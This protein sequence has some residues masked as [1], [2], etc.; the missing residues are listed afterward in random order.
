MALE[1]F[2][3]RHALRRGKR[4]DGLVAER[5]LLGAG[6]ARRLGH[7]RRAV[8]HQRLI[9]LVRPIPFQHGEFRVMQ[10]AALAV[11]EH[12]G[13]FEN[14]CLAGRQQLLAGKFRRG[15]QVKR[16]LLVARPDQVGGKGMQM[17]LVAGRNLQRCRLHL[18]E[19]ASGKPCPHSGGNPPPR[20][21]IGPAG[22][23]PAGQ[24][25][26]RGFAQR[27]PQQNGLWYLQEKT[28]GKGWHRPRRSLWCGPKLLPQ[29]KD[30]RREGH[31]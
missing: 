19:I 13:E 31:R 7:Q 14:A 2:R 24:P 23:M 16:T 20:Q 3:H 28:L 6:G 26:R 1:G 12:A 30:S 5:E 21:Q 10:R 15:P 25:E 29:S 8:V 18:E 27:L 4:I 11:A 22:G 17:C 9:R